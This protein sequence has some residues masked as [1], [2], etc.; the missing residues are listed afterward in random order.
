MYVV[1]QIIA[2]LILLGSVNTHCM[3]EKTPASDLQ[4]YQLLKVAEQNTPLYLPTDIIQGI[5]RKAHEITELRFRKRFDRIGYLLH[6]INTR[7]TTEKLTIH[8]I[9]TCLAKHD[10]SLA[11]FKHPTKETA[12]HMVMGQPMHE[13]DFNYCFNILCQV[14]GDDMMT[15]LPLR[16]CCNWTSWHLAAHH[17]HSEAI[18]KFNTIAREKCLSLTALGYDSKVLYIAKAKSSQ[19]SKWIAD[20][21]GSKCSPRYRHEIDQ[22]QIIIEL[23]E[24]Y[25]KEQIAD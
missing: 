25:F 22:L 11:T 24:A 19:L 4:I 17:A 8:I 16:D 5:M 10:Q 14:A 23:L 12:L 3:F 18:K 20:N 15:I 13:E 1:K 7:P 2:N 21:P 9:Q 6:F